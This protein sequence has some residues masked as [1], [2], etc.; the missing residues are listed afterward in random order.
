MRAILP[1][2]AMAG[3]L[4]LLTAAAAQE[5]KPGEITAAG[6][7]LAKALDQMDV[8][9]RWLVASPV[10]WRTGEPLE[11]KTADGKHH[12]HCSAFAAA[13]AAELGIYLLRPPQHSSA[14]LAGAQYDWLAGDGKKE[15]WQPVATAAES[16]QLANRGYLVVAVYKER[17]PQKPGHVAIV[18]PSVKSAA[19]I[20]EEGPQIIQ[21]G[22][23]NHASTSL[24]EGFKHHPTA[25]RDNLIRFYA[26]PIPAKQDA[27]S[28]GK[29]KK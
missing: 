12:T 5:P 14:L 6:Q 29:A 25:L 26:H 22:M 9:H 19:Q 16:Q 8:E 24:K 13:A 11:G 1:V 20:R 23:E 10:K 27:D 15:G 7:H 21:A 28:G 3:A 2:G 17:D 4:L 18:R